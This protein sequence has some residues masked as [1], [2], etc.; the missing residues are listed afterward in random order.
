M[1][2][3]T[4]KNLTNPINSSLRSKLEEAEKGEKKRK[5]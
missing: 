4:P 1:H 2:S 3:K 5:K